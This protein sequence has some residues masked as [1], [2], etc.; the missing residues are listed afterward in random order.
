MEELDI[1]SKHDYKRGDTD[2]WQAIREFWDEHYG[3]WDEEDSMDSYGRNVRTYTLATG[4]W[5]ENEDIIE[6]MQQNR[7]LWMT[8]WYQSTRG[9]LHVFKVAQPE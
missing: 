3:R 4:G 1:I 6:A 5:S 2:F 9:G 7:F 8:C